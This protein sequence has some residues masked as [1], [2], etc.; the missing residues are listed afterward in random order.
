MLVL[1]IGKQ[2]GKKASN[3][4]H[5]STWAAC[6]HT[7]GDRERGVAL[8]LPPVMDS[9]VRVEST[10][11]HVFE[12][13]PT[14]V[15]QKSQP[16]TDEN[17]SKKCASLAVWHNQRVCSQRKQHQGVEARSGWIYF[18]HLFEKHLITFMRKISKKITPSWTHTKLKIS[19]SKRTRQH[20][21]PLSTPRHGGNPR[22][23]ST[24]DSYPSL[25][26]KFRNKKTILATAVPKTFESRGRLFGINSSGKHFSTPRVRPHTNLSR[27]G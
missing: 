2:V 24:A 20:S 11:Q 21:P 8:A 12:T 3:H 27:G 1:G 5:A 13:H 23:G 26:R 18:W 16:L 9:I 19:G 6:R 25:K 7:S 10:L 22:L 17:S 15:V 4:A 14:T